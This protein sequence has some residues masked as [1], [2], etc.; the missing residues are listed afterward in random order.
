MLNVR[1]KNSSI[2]M[3]ALI[4]LV[5]ILPCWLSVQYICF[6]L[7]TDLKNTMRLKFFRR[8]WQKR[9]YYVSKIIFCI[10]CVF[11]NKTIFSTFICLK[12]F[13]GSYFFS[14]AYHS[15]YNFNPYYKLLISIAIFVLD[16]L[17]WMF[18]QTIAIYPGPLSVVG[19]ALCVVCKRDI[20]FFFK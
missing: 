9:I 2:K 3:N 4:S 13:Q 15:T 14:L 1:T 8:P 19:S 18:R 17:S 10:Y 5:E 6:V 7:L 20:L 12:Y 16:H 11:N